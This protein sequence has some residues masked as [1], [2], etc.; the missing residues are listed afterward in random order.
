MIV[1]ILVIFVAILFSN[2]KSKDL[3]T[4]K[5]NKY[6]FMYFCS[7]V[8]LFVFSAIRY[9]VGFDYSYTYTKFYNQLILGYNVTHFEPLFLLLNKFVYCVF[10]NVDFVFIIS[11]FI[12]VGL[13]FKTIKKQSSIIPLS[14]FLLIGS[15]FYFYSFTQVRQYIAIAIFIY[16][17]QFI[18]E[19]KFFKYIIY[20]LIASMFHK[21]ALVYIPLY[22]VRNIRLTK[23]KYLLLL[24]STFFLG[25]LITPVYTFLASNFYSS[26]DFVATNSDSVSSVFIILAVFNAFLIYL[27]FDKLKNNEYNNLYIFMHVVLIFIICSTYNITDSYRLVALFSYHTIFLIPNIIKTINNKNS[28]YI[29]ITLLIVLYG[30][31]TISYIKSDETMLPYKTIFNKK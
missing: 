23:K 16:S 27:Y 9:D 6:K 22:F 1:Y 14:V 12:T 25:V 2:V 11:S 13:M 10:D 28:F 26:Y 18:I 20:I 7:F 5:L 31:S 19:G 4:G 21:L 15:R 17:L 8:V 3:N 30:A 29:I 24:I